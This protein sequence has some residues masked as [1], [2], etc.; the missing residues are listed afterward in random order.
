MPAN[1]K[2]IL[3]AVLSIFLM[4]S[5]LVGSRT[6]F[7]DASILS[8][9]GVRGILAG[10]LLLV[11]F[12]K[13]VLSR[14]SPKGI[15]WLLA[16]VGTGY[17]ASHFL[18]IH[19][20]GETPATYRFVIALTMPLWAY[21]LGVILRQESWNPQK[22]GGMA[23]CF[24]AY[25]FQG[26][27]GLTQPM[28]FD[29]SG[30]LILLGATA[31]LASSLFFIQKALAELSA[32]VCAT[33]FLLIGGIGFTF[34][35]FGAHESIFD[36][37]MGSAENLLYLVFDVAIATALGYLLMFRA[38]AQ[39]GPVLIAALFF[40]KP[41]FTNVINIVWW[42]GEFTTNLLI[43]SGVVICGLAATLQAGKT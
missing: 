35:T 5:Q 24:A 42:D 29:Y 40:L 20:G 22:F 25:L 4:A 1:M 11:I 6:V 31:L 18:A 12:R 16:G 43:V 2:T 9:Y 14:L 15:L 36:A 37:G 41:I 34:L 7:S 33:L 21:L 32:E 13:E 28:F 10:L 23:F 30:P 27:G 17:L 8:V 19:G 26:W 3:L 39:I 38:I